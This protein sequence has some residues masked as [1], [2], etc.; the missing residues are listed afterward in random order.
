MPKWILVVLILACVSVG[1]N[2]PA[3][4]PPASCP[5]C[6]QV[7]Q[8]LEDLGSLKAGM[9][10]HDAEQYFALDGGMN[11]R[12]QTRYVYKKCEFIQVEVTFEEDPD[13]RNDFSQKDKITKL[14][15]LFLEFPSKD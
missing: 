8:A 9:T 15:K 6:G 1:T 14:S 4:S 10:R 13:V 2:L 5:P 11:F 12:A 7:V 3:Q